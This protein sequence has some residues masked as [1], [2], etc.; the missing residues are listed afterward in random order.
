MTH[1]G[2][3]A[4]IEPWQG[5]NPVQNYDSCTTIS[6]TK[7]SKRIH[8][9]GLSYPAEGKGIKTSALSTTTKLTIQDVTA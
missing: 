2:T 6:S 3:A 7:Q 4:R 1:F 9:H 5:T 8:L